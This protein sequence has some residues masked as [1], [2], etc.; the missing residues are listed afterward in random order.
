MGG[1]LFLCVIPLVVL[2]PCSVYNIINVEELF[3]E[4]YVVEK[5]M[6]V[7]QD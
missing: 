5:N 6:S 3:S 1:R 2:L 4:F 7:A